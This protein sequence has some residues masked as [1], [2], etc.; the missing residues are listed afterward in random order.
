MH[1]LESLT[2]GCELNAMEEISANE[3]SVGRILPM[4]NTSVTQS[5]VDIKIIHK[6][7]NKLDQVLQEEENFIYRSARKSIKFSTNKP[8]TNI[9]V[10]RALQARSNI[11]RN[12]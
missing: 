7:E 2:S 12:Y 3:S 5:S 4:D 11:S 6:N 10:N 8:K 9:K 1:L